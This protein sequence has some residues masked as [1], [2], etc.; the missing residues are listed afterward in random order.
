MAEA[1]TRLFI[2]CT[3]ASRAQMN[4]TL[5]T[6]DPA[7]TGDVMVVPLSLPTA[8]TVPVARWTLWAMPETHRQAILAAFTST[9]WAPLKGS[10]GRVLQPTDPVP[11][12]GSQRFWLLDGSWQPDAVLRSLG[13]R[14]LPSE[15]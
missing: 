8:P 7:S 6:I 5:N 10:E 2:V 1:S 3:E 14:L 9:G 12:W 15:E 13:L 11:A 4:S